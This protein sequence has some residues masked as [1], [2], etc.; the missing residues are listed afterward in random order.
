[1]MRKLAN[2][3]RSMKTMVWLAPLQ[4][5]S[6]LSEIVTS[7]LMCA[8]VSRLVAQCRITFLLSASIS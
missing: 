7:E 4:K 2:V 6:S 1:M 3:S 8:G 5:M